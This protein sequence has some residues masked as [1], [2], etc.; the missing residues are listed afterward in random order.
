MAAQGSI[1]TKSVTNISVSLTQTTEPTD[2]LFEF[3]AG[4]L[5]MRIHQINI[6][7]NSGFQANAYYKISIDGVIQLNN[8]FQ[9]WNGAAAILSVIPTGKFFPLI[10]N[11]SVKIY[12]YNPSGQSTQTM[13]ISVEV[14]AEVI[15]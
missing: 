12:A 10:A 2:P 5:P 1:I 4:N 15:N 11:G 9:A 14:M 8:V 6:S 3:D 13:S 7:V